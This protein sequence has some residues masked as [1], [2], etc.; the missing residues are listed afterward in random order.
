M[1][2]VM[3]CTRWARE[4]SRRLRPAV[5]M[6]SSTKLVQA[7]K[8]H[9]RRR[10]RLQQS[11]CLGGHH[12][13][14]HLTETRFLCLLKVRQILIYACTPRSSH[15]LTEVDGILHTAVL[16]AIRSFPLASLPITASLFYSTHILPS[17]PAE[18]TLSTSTPVDI[19]HSSFKSLA[20]FLRTHERDGLLTLKTTR[21][22][23][24]IT[25][26]SEGYRESEQ[27]HLDSMHTVAKAQEDIRR[28]D[29]EE[30][31]KLTEAK[32]MKIQRL[33]QPVGAT[34][35]WFETLGAE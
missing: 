30:R 12:R 24:M 4:H 10:H 3:P 1:Q 29:E 18:P 21:N 17:R 6:D 13:P 34:K 33:W 31:S 27:L 22:G 32:M 20:A 11:H 14:R 9:P 15:N 35:A 19:K 23:E 7:S 26:L 28:N 5:M 16:I 8:R 25:M 2:L